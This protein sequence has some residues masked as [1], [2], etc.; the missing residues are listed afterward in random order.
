[1][2]PIRLLFGHGSLSAPIFACLVPVT[3]C[4]ILSE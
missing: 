1:M 2:I 3:T 4:P